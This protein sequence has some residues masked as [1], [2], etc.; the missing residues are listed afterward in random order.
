MES[1]GRSGMKLNNNKCEFMVAEV[2][3]LGH[4]I[5]S[6][7]IKPDPEKIHAIADMPIPQNKEE[8]QRFLGMTNYLC[9]FIHNYSEITN[10]L[11]EI[12]KKEITWIFEEQQEQAISELKKIITSNQVLK[13]YDPKLPIRLTSDASQNGLG[14]VLEQKHNERWLPVAFSSRAL[15]QAEKELQSN[16]NTEYII[17]M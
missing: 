4:L 14:S 6:E 1:I 8:L 11:R 5:S 7:G 17:W 3:F 13:F 9:K 10:P 16:R 12:L 15:S 2:K